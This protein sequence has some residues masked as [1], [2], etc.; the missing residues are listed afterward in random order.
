M[1]P[2]RAFSNRTTRI[3]IASSSS[4][5]TKAIAAAAMSRI[6]ITLLNWLKKIRQ[7]EVVGGSG[8][9]LAPYCARRAWISVAANPFSISV[10]NSIAVWL[11]VRACQFC[12]MLF[13]FQDRLFERGNCLL[14]DH[15]Q[16]AQE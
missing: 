5:R 11:G 3:E 7:G 15:P 6:V 16:A 9:L 2:S 4:P 10:C 8:S 13:F 1:K 14:P 12:F